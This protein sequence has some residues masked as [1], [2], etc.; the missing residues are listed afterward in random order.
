MYHLV[1]IPNAGVFVYPD[2]MLS[3]NTK[4][5]VIASSNNEQELRRKSQIIWQFLTAF[6]KSLEA[7]KK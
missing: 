1:M 2:E 3:E 7:N 4:Q 6:A 5:F